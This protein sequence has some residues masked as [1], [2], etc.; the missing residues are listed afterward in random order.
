[1]FYIFVIPIT[2]IACFNCFHIH[3][4]AH[5]ACDL[6]FIVNGEG[7]F[8][9]TGSHV[10][11]NSSNISETMLDEDAATRPLTTRLI[12]AYTYYTAYLIAAIVMTLNVLEGYSPIASL[13]KCDI[14]YL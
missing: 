3:L 12:G 9:V 8:K 4:K 5:A 13:F 14:S 1:M 6:N 7:L 10:H 11:W 2:H